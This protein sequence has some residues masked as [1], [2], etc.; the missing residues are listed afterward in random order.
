[1]KDVDRAAGITPESESTELGVCD[2]DPALNLA[3]W[4]RTVRTRQDKCNGN[5]I[6]MRI[7]AERA[8]AFG[9]GNHA[10][11]RPRET[12]PS[13]ACAPCPEAAGGKVPRARL[14]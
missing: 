10:K 2:N 9:N 11:S 7:L 5:L 1:M 12:Y 6:S 14:M 4:P 3:I 8:H 13:C